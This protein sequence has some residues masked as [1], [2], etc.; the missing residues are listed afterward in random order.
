MDVDASDTVVV[1]DT[2]DCLSDGGSSDDDSSEEDEPEEPQ[3]RNKG[4]KLRKMKDQ[5]AQTGGLGGKTVN[6]KPPK[7]SATAVGQQVAKMRMSVPMLEMVEYRPYLC[8]YILNYCIE[9]A[10]R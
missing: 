8:R 6:T 5:G 1:E 10:A 9:V 7:L 4:S 3:P 2:E